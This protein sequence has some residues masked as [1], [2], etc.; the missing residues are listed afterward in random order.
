MKYLAVPVEFRGL[1]LVALENVRK[2]SEVPVEV[3]TEV[4]RLMTLIQMAYA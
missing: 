2:P 1:I 4:D 3:S